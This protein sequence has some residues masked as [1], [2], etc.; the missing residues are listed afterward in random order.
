M[1][2]FK[3]SLSGLLKIREFNETK[4]KTELGQIVGQIDSLKKQ[5][6]DIHKNMKNYYHQQ[7]EMMAQ[8]ITASEIQ[9]FPR[10]ISALKAKLK[11]TE[12]ELEETKER[13]KRKTQDLA[14][15]MADVKLISNLKDKK[16][17][18]FLKELNKKNE[19]EIEENN[20]RRKNWEAL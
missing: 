12:Q 4:I 16:R 1:K 6:E 20:R 10:F 7:E 14:K 15:A 8:E 2:E 9:Q 17:S 18:D 3:F 5:I 13:Y 19:M 11:A